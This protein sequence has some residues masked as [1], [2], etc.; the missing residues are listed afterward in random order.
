MMFVM[1]NPMGLCH[2]HKNP[3]GHFRLNT[4]MLI[5]L[6]TGILSGKNERRCMKRISNVCEAT[7]LCQKSS[8]DW[9]SIVS[10]YL[11]CGIKA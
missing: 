3:S 9:R 6:E 1:K 5:L 2:Y 10:A 7:E 11:S 4:Y 8:G